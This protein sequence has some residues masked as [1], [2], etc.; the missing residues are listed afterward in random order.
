MVHKLKH[1]SHPVNMWIAAG[2][3]IHPKMT[4]T[5]AAA[6]QLFTSMVVV[7]STVVGHTCGTERHGKGYKLIMSPTRSSLISHTLNRAMFV[8]N[9][10]NLINHNCCQSF[11]VDDFATGFLTPDQKDLL[12]AEEAFSHIRML[13]ESDEQ[14][15]VEDHS[16]DGADEGWRGDGSGGDEGEDDEKD[17]DDESMEF[18]PAGFSV[19]DICPTLDATL[20]GKFVLTYWN[21]A[22]GRG[23]SRK[24]WGEWHLGLVEI[25][26]NSTNAPKTYKKFNFLI[27]FNEGSRKVWL[28]EQMYGKDAEPGQAVKWARVVM[29]VNH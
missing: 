8:Y 9:N 12:E 22:S 19:V 24:T 29:V 23:K 14:S 20:E 3:L 13:E 4:T 27:K 25:A 6:H 17:D 28:S 7:L 16:G 18:P 15:D 11:D 2:N 10:Y 1:A 26:Y 5:Q 21:F